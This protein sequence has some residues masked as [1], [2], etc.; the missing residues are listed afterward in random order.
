MIIRKQL[1]F[2][3]DAVKIAQEG[4]IPGR[5]RPTI[6]QIGIIRSIKLGE[7]ESSGLVIIDWD[8]GEWSENS[9]AVIFVNGYLIK[10]FRTTP[11]SRLDLI[12][13]E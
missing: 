3:G 11:K 9:C 8:N 5:Y 2:V 12:N 1:F 10:T 7:L 4:T 13:M 6:N